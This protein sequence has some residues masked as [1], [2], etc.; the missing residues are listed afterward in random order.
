[1]VTAAPH[2]NWSVLYLP[3]FGSFW[4]Q[5]CVALCGFHRL[6]SKWGKPLPQS[7]FAPCIFMDDL[8]ISR[9]KQVDEVSCTTHQTARLP[10]HFC[11]RKVTTGVE[12]KAAFFSRRLL[13]LSKLPNWIVLHKLEFPVTLR[14]TMQWECM[15]G[16]TVHTF[17]AVSSLKPKWKK[18]FKMCVSGKQLSETSFLVCCFYVIL[19]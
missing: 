17:R 2:H 16:C 18:Y 1:M 7:W 10:V 15:W 14:N 3:T 12:K 5:N 4:P 19:R 13:R 11:S 9:A 6:R 8:C